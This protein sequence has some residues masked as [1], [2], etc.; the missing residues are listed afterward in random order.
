ML[1]PLGRRRSRFDHRVVGAYLV[2]AIAGAALTATL[3]WLLSGFL[4]PLSGT[5]RT[6]LLC[7]GAL[8]LWAAKDGPL[9]RRVTL[10]ETRRQ[11]PSAIFATSL[12][13]GAYR[14][15]FEMGTGMRTYV[16]SFAPYLLLLA[17][18]VA[19]PTLGQ[20]LLI[21]V[22]FGLGRAIPLMIRLRPE[23]QKTMT[24]DFLQGRVYRMT[25]T[26]TGLVVLVGAL[27]L[28]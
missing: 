19:R 22:G 14:F 27:L 4:E 13:R 8:F 5:A 16:P 25:Q 23:D 15:G 11:I 18:L 3:A 6:A 12:V 21:A 26:A 9:A 24:R 2:G 28:V 7:A 1:L 17:L 10:P 20:A